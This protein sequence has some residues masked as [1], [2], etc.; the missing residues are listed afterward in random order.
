MPRISDFDKFLAD[1]RADKAKY[2]DLS[3]RKAQWIGKIDALYGQV[4]TL[5]EPYQ[6]NGS[7]EFTRS[8][9]EIH[10]EE[11]GSYQAPSLT[12]N[13]GASSVRFMPIGTMLLGSPGRVDLVGL[14]GSVRF[15]LVLPDMDRPMH[16]A[17]AEPKRGRLDLA[18]YIWKISTSPPGIRYSVIDAASLQS[19]IMEAAN[20]HS[21]HR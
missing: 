19:A 4:R 13:L 9:S 7:M 18:P 21:R 11:L 17:A 2:G 3:E 1:Q 8:L 14:R 16:M 10:E 20:G 6:A 12:I 15:I 5:L